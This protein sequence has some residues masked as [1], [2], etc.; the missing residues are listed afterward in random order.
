MAEPVRIGIVGVGAIG[1]VHA[2]AL[3]KVPGAEVVALCDILP[4][5]LREKGWRH[6]VDRLYEDYREMVS[7]PDIDA[8]YVC[9]PNRLH[10]EVAVAAFE[11]GKHVFLEK[12]MALNAREGEDICAAR[13][14]AGKVLQMGMVQR[15]RDDSQVVKEL[16]DKGELGEIYHIRVTLLRRR[17]IPGLGGWFTT[18]SESG[19]GPLIDIGVHSFDLAMWLSGLWNPTAVSAMTYAKFGPR[20]EDYHYVGMWAGPPDYAGTFDVEDYACG[21]VRFGDKATMTFNVAWAANTEGGNFVEL[22]GTRAGVCRSGGPLILRGEYDDRPADIQIQHPTGADPY[23]RENEKFVAAVRGEAPPAATG[24]EGVVAMK[25]IDAIYRSAQ[26]G[27]EVAV[28]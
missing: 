2:D 28:E 5:R 9:V 18:K 14:K 6:G 13:D 22:L 7:L 4:D 12:P 21:M 1:S 26:E 3:A 23:V 15:Q 11:A 25:L 24:E 20:M 10:K 19:G 17:G 16:I 27:R 8:V